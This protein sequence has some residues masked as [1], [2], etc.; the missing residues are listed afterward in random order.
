MSHTTPSPEAIRAELEELIVRDL[1]GPVDGP[2]E[3]LPGRR[4]VRDRYLVGMLAPTGTV[5][6]TPASDVSDATGSNTPDEG[7]PDHG[8][9]SVVSFFPS[10]VGLTFVVPAAV[11]K[12][13]CRVEWG[14]YTKHQELQPVR[15]KP[16][17][18]EAAAAGDSQLAVLALPVVELETVPYWQR[19]PI[20]GE[21]VVDLGRANADG[22]LPP[23][24]PV[25]AFPAVWIRGRVRM[26]D[27]ARLVTLFLVNEQHEP[28][29]NRDEAW[30]YQ[31]RIIVEG[32]EGGPVFI[33]REDALQRTVA[34][35]GEEAEMQMLGMLY[36]NHVSF[37][38]GHGTSVHATLA[39]GDPSRA[40]R[41]ETVA[42]PTHEVPATEAPAPDDAALPEDVSSE[43]RQVELDMKALSALPDAAIPAAVEPLVRAYELWLDHQE[44]RIG[45]PAARLGPHKDAA[46]V[47]IA[48]ARKTAGRLREGIKALADPDAAEAFR[49]ANHAMWQQRIHSIAIARRRPDDE[50]DPLLDEVD[51]EPRNHRWRPFQLAFILLNLPSLTDPGHEERA[52]QPHGEG[53]VDLLFF[54]TGG[55]KTEAYLGLTAYT[56]AIRRLQGTVGGYDGRSGGVAVLMRYTLRLLTSQQVQ[57][58]AALICA[59]EVARRERVQHDP[60]WGDTP[61]RIGMWVGASVT[62]NR[63]DDAKKQI[64][65]ARAPRGGSG[66]ASPLQL[67]ACPWCGTALTLASSVVSDVERRRIIQFCPDPHGACAFSEANAP[68]EGLPVVTVDEE[69]YRLLPSVVIGTADKFAQLP[70]QGPLHLLFGKVSRRCTRHGYRSDDL[71]QVG[72]FKE[73]DKHH[74]TGKLPAAKTEAVG[75]LRPPDLI[76]QDELHLI[77]GPLGTMVGLYETAIDMLAS[78]ELNGKRVRPKVIASTATIRRAAEQAHALFWRG[79]EVFPPPVLDVE[80]SFFALQRPT[81][82]AGAQPG[83]RYLGVCAH[84]RRLKE[85]EVRLFTTVMAAAQVI[86]EKYGAAADP[87][88][89]CVGYFN[90]LRELGGAKRLMDD[91][92]ASRLRSADQRGFVRRSL[93]VTRELTSRIG[94]AD[95]P[96]TLEQLSVQHDPAVQ[97][98]AEANK[99]PYLPVDVLLATNM[100]SV[101]VDVP[102]LGLMVAVGQPKATAEYIQATSRVG[103]DPRGPGLVVTLYNWARPRDL[104]H[105]EVFESYHDTFYRHVEALSVTPYSPRALDRGL[106]AVLV[107]LVRHS[108][109]DWTWNPNAGARVVPSHHAQ[110]L[111]LVQEIRRR[112]GD[113]TGLPEREAEIVQ[114]LTAK[115]D[116]WAQE[117]QK[118]QQMGSTLAYKE[119]RK[120]ASAAIGLLRAPDLVHWDAFTC[121]NSLRE[122]EPSVQLLLQTE[123]P[124]ATALR[125]YPG[126]PDKQN[127]SSPQLTLVSA[128][129]AEAPIPEAEIPA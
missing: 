23:R 81:T 12:L 95:I 24:T 91:E 80:D 83:R 128:E 48:R 115:L 26:L 65:E 120:A 75:P 67:L 63:F 9:T 41:V 59:C 14:H 44:A 1:Y 97:A 117:Q 112:A 21:L 109:I 54:P 102:R 101:G 28:K 84:G 30:L 29:R 7:M 62:P 125:P 129:D 68:L 51:A 6:E 25:Q 85:A 72:T 124:S 96:A 69:M 52:G 118:H 100:I 98:Q 42:L 64:E 88:M 71:D 49:F 127:A 20:E 105:Y 2:E 8:A 10:S 79:L 82:G 33:G 3:K 113:V 74:A 58:A 55:G 126:A 5:G 77:T 123:D 114:A 17:P 111:A 40:V 34:L 43:L 57:R 107:A 45:D 66:K 78:W 99:E 94:S 90:A 37:A 92:V 89:T 87:W 22:I 121:P 35:A 73:A 122:T 108:G 47:S 70:W 15:K 116:R 31:A 38:V 11:T 19:M 93:R 76:I 4:R 50:L 110:L 61:F 13:R 86:Y 106:A 104:S 53:L 119:D 36:R 18:A 16:G 39:P 60:R 32:A 27:H 56:L 46:G 103:R